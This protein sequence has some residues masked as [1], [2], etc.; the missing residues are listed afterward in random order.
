MKENQVTLFQQYLRFGKRM[1]E[2]TST[3]YLSDLDQFS[4]YLSGTYQIED[5]SLVKTIHIRSFLIHLIELKY[6]ETAIKR[7][8]SSLK[9]FFKFMMRQNI[10]QI[11]PCTD[12]PIPK[13]KS[14]L[15]VYLEQNQSK[16]LF[17]TVVFPESFDGMTHQLILEILYQTGIR[18]M[19]LITLKERDVDFYRDEIVV[20]GKRN[21]ERAI[22]ICEDLKN[23][24]KNYIAEKKRQIICNH[25]N[26][27]TLNSGGPLYDNYVYRVVTKYLNTNIT[28]LSKRSPHVLRHTFATQLTNNGASINAIKELL[29]HSS[30]ASTQV[31]THLDIEH[32]RKVYL[33]AHPKA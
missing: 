29:G 7:K 4:N 1:S 26:L 19:E 8:I 23:L 10:V 12:L 30:L 5:L 16:K 24:I 21:K 28:T 14:L 27:L 13:K 25:K 15:P 31:Y 22:P 2:H 18:R 20:L 33:K 11:N 17:E 9:S 3:A 6:K 32:L